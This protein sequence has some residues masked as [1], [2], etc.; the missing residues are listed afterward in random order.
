MS[1]TVLEAMKLDTFKNFRLIAGHRGFENKIERVGILDYEYDKR[2]EGQLYKGQ[3]EKA[4]FVISSLLFAKDDASL[5][6]DAVK[7]LLNDKVK[8]LSFKVNRF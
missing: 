5:I 8:G 6:F 7:C 3:F 4:Q 2:I 1:I